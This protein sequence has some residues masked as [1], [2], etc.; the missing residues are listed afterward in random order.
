MR[1]DSPTTS[2]AAAGS[3]THTSRVS[4]QHVSRFCLAVTAVTAV[5][6]TLRVWAAGGGWFYWDD[7]WWH[8]IVASNSLLTTAGLSLGGHYSPL[9]YV[10]YW[11]LTAAFPYEW[12]PRVAVMIVT[13]LGI[14]AGVLAVSRRLWP[15][16]GPQLAVYVLWASST[17]I[18]PS[19]LW[20]SQFSMTGAL[21]LT[22]TWTLWAY[23]RAL[24][25]SSFG[26]SLLAVVLLT[27]SLFTQERMVV[28]AVIMTV[29]LTW[30]VRPTLRLPSGR[31]RKGL[32]GASA[33]AMLVWVFVY[34]SLP[35]EK[36]N[37]PTVG[38]AIEL[39][40]AMIAKSGL[41]GVLSGPWVLDGTPVLHRS[42][43]PLW[44]SAPAVVL[45]AALVALSLGS[46]RRAWR[47]WVLLSG[48]MVVAAGLVVFGRGATMGALVAGE[49]RYFSE[50]A[51]L[52]P[53]LVVSAFVAPGTTP[54]RSLRDGRVG[55]VLLAV[56]CVGSLITTVQL[57]IGW[58]QSIARPFVE[59]TRAELQSSGPRAVMDTLLPETVVNPPLGLQRLASRVF[60]IVPSE[61]TF[62]EPST[63]PYTLDDRGALVE[64][65]LTERR[66]SPGTGP[67]PYPVEGVDTTWVSLPGEFDWAD[68]GARIDYES[69]ATQGLVLTDGVRYVTVEVPP[70][71]HSLFV[72]FEALG[73][74]L[75]IF[76]SDPGQSLCVSRV[77]TGTAV[78]R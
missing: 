62:N 75:G 10:P 51:V 56:Y 61:V 42:A 5:Q 59:R 30:V 55:V 13:L 66:I 54:Q 19:W 16:R 11:L 73:G 22:S 57:G 33:I 37:P 20:Y 7:F 45:V 38:S 68:W 4:R 8:D 35:A 47:A 12:A 64:G 63:Q 43:F 17:L 34:L 67:C 77:V 41:P 70:G 25:S 15:T 31:D 14:N 50:L 74:Q 21:L 49:W 40:A 65:A 24:Q 28:V 69:S 26:A 23:L 46:N 2:A 27:V 58:H 39:T 29:L 52:A 44:M 76:L 72:P 53:L 6:V 1:V 78:P 18:A 36:A 71:N 60:S 48:A 9:T 3:D 32:W